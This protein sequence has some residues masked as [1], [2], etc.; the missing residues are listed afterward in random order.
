MQQRQ[1]VCLL[2]ITTQD[3]LS[4]ICL[5]GHSEQLIH[6]LDIADA[7]WKSATENGTHTGKKLRQSYGNAQGT[8][9]EAQERHGDETESALENI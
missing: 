1:Q 8:S 4:F 7:F 6:T 5:H 9:S 2:R 3:H